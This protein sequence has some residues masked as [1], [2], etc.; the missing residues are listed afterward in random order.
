MQKVFVRKK[1]DLQKFL[2]HC[3]DV[4]TIQ[5]SHHRFFTRGYETF[6]QDR[7]N[8]PKAGVVTLVRNSIPPIEVQR[9]GAGDT[10]CL[11]VELILPDKHLQVFNIYSPPDKPI[12]LHSIDNWIIMRLQ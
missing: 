2:K 8:R 10:E 11:G 9:S 7:E 6:R 12:T 4:C 5:E 1:T 3:I